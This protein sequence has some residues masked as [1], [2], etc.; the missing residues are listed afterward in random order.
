M[1]MDDRWG[2]LWLDDDD[3]DDNDDADVL[4]RRCFFLYSLTPP[5]LI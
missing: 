3:D 5:R 2:H 1:M 4:S